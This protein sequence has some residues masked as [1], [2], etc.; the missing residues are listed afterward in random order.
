MKNFKKIMFGI[1]L[2]LTFLACSDEEPSL[3]VLNIK[4]LMEDIKETLQI[5]WE[6]LDENKGLPIRQ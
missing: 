1:V 3:E 2:S 6:I 4:N 5:F